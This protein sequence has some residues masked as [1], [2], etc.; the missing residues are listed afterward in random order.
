[1]LLNF[2][3][4]F[5]SLN[6]TSFANM[7]GNNFFLKTPSP[8]FF[9]YFLFRLKYVEAVLFE[10]QRHGS[11]VPISVPH[12]STK[13]VYFDDYIIPKVIKKIFFYL[14]ILLVSPLPPPVVTTRFEFFC[15]LFHAGHDDFGKFTKRS[16]GQKSLGRPG[17][18]S[19]GKIYR[20]R[21]ANRTKRMVYTL[22]TRCKFYSDIFFFPFS[23]LA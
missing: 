3:P 15:F 9:F 1:M 6:P 13:D 11:V 18:F 2:I 19:S 12:R 5:F 17:K 10:V 14:F 7:D 23:S 4:F 16:H 22:R 20:F 21:W 8:L